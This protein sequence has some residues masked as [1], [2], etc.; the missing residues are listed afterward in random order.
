MGIETFGELVRSKR[1][2]LCMSQETLAKII[3]VS[4]VTIA[5]IETGQWYTSFQNAV[6]IASVLGLDLNQFKYKVKFKKKTITEM[7]GL[8]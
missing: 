6:R 8:E 7:V 2:V 4:R 1:Q 5:N 3:S